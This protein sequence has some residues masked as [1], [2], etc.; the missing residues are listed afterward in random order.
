MWR[1]SQV[2]ST[3]Q[4]IKVLGCPLGHTDFVD[5]HLEGTSVLLERIPSVPDQSAWLLLTHCSQG[6]LPFTRAP[7]DFG[8]QV[9]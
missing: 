7:T 5:A 6:H 8:A 4:G 3:E 9:C 1:G 2:P